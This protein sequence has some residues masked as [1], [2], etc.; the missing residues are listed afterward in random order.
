MDEQI[1]MA[2]STAAEFDGH[3]V[4]AIAKTHGKSA[5]TTTFVLCQLVADLTYLRASISC[6]PR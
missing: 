4:P 6:S 2:L 1:D 5:F 3:F